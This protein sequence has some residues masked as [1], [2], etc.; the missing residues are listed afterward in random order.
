MVTPY[1]FPKYGLGSTSE[2]S[3]SGQIPRLCVRA[4]GVSLQAVANCQA[5]QESVVVWNNYAK[6]MGEH[7]HEQSIRSKGP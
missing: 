6:S 7:R 4:V 1:T 5:I 3:S 2:A